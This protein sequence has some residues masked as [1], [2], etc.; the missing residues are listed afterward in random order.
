[1]WETQLAMIKDAEAQR[2]LYLGVSHSPR[3]TARAARYGYATALLGGGGRTH[4]ALHADYTNETWF[5]EYDYAI[6]DAG[7]RGD[8]RRERRAPARVHERSRARQPDAERGARRVRRRVQ[9]LRAERRD[10]RDDARRTP[11]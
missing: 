1:M 5:P 10:R 8:A 9:R 11:R 7:R 4:F 2:K 3:T 6:G